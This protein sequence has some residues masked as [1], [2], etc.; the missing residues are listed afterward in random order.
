MS[1]RRVRRIQP[2]IPEELRER[3]GTYCAASGKPESTVVREAL[4]DHFD[5]TGDLTLLQRSLDRLT[6]ASERTRRDIE[7]LSV[8][9]ATFVRLW[10]AHTPQIAEDA[11]KT[12]RSSA[13]MRYRQFMDFVANEYA[14]GKRFI[15]DLPQE[16]I[17]DP[18]ELAAVAEKAQKT[19]VRQE[20]AS[21]AVPAASR[22][23]T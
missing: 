2:Y 12:V 15:D 10:F 4:Q 21:L 18:R 23:P 11:R 17:A 7:V 13:E 1:R 3:L 14:G 9:F 16:I 20:T 8:G 19:S 22:R 6:R 5:G